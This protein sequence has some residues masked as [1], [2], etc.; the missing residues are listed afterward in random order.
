M[1]D[2]NGNRTFVQA[3]VNYRYQPY[4]SISMVA[5][6]NYLDLPEP[7]GENSFLLIGPKVD[8]TFTR[9][10]FFT[11]FVQYNEQMDNLNINSRFQ[12]RYSPV[13]DIFIVYKDNYFPEMMDSRNRAVVFKMSYW[14]N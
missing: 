6:Y 2:Y 3:D 10:L 8:I 13:S 14:F 5:S 11:T 7:W 1:N 4:G 12:W 9:S